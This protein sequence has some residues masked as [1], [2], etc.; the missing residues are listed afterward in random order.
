VIGAI[1]ES[2]KA[3]NTRSVNRVPDHV[4]GR[5][6]YLR[7]GST[8]CLIPAAMKALAENGRIP[9]VVMGSTPVILVIYNDGQERWVCP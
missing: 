9:D 8:G 7:S 5:T 1:G 4:D 6:A 3:L 2:I